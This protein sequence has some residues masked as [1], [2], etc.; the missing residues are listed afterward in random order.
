MFPSDSVSPSALAACH[1]SHNQGA[2]RGRGASTADTPTRPRASATG[3]RQ[4]RG[5]AIVTLNFQEGDGSAPGEARDRI[6]PALHR[7]LAAIERLETCVQQRRDQDTL[8]ADTVQ[9]LENE[10]NQA[11]SDYDTLKTASQQV[12]ER[13]DQTIDRVR[14]TLEADDPA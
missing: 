3:R 4:Q 10:L 7:L 6:A 11:R 14:T 1:L 5:E 12:R 9:A 2:I 13:L 8:T